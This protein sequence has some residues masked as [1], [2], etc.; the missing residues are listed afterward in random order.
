LFI[1]VGIVIVADKMKIVSHSGEIELSKIPELHQKW[2]D[3]WKKYWE[4]KD[5]NSPLPYDPLCEITIPATNENMQ[6]IK[7]N[8]DK[9]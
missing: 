3:Y 7:E 6:K 1:E 4:V 8:I 9:K 5:S 2:W